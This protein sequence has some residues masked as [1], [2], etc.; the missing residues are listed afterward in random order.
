MRVEAHPALERSLL[1]HPLEVAD[2]P[3]A[4][5]EVR[6][7]ACPHRLDAERDRYMGLADARAPDEDTFSRR[8]RKKG[9][10]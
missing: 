9:F 7:L 6:E 2:E 5:D 1:G 8:S 4:G 10:E 3:L